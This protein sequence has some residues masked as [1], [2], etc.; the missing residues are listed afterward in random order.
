MKRD[1]SRFYVFALID[2]RVTSR[3]LG[4]GGMSTS[5]GQPLA[6]VPVPRTHAYAVVDRR[7]AARATG[8]GWWRRPFGA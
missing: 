3:A 4:K 5:R 6:L 1:A 7:A 2:T 8:A